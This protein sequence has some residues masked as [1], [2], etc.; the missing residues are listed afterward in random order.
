MMEAFKR[1]KRWKKDAGLNVGSN[2]VTRHVEVD[3]DKLPLKQRLVVKPRHSE[4]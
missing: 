3:P 1:C 2:D 4:P